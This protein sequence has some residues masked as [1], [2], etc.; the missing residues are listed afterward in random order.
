MTNEARLS[1]E[2]RRRVHGAGPTARVR[3]QWRPD[4]R[5]VLRSIDG[6]HMVVLGMGVPDHISLDGRRVSMSEFF[7]GDVLRENLAGFQRRVAKDA[8]RELALIEAAETMHEEALKRF[9]VEELAGHGNKDQARKVEALTL[10][11]FASW[12]LQAQ[13]VAHRYCATVGGTVEAQFY[14][15][16]GRSPALALACEELGDGSERVLPE[17]ED[18]ERLAQAIGSNPSIDR[19]A[20]LIERLVTERVSKAGAK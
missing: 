10:D 8:K 1:P 15:A 2:D 7:V 17:H 16:H 11:D 9:L 19:L 5:R 12:P 20:D 14:R 18:R 6:E 13:R 4:R 3:I